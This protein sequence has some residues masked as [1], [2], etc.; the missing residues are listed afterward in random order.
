M[1]GMYIRVANRIVN[2]TNITDIEEHPPEEEGQ[3]RALVINFVGS[4]GLTLRG[5]E[6]DLFLA[7]LPVY[8]PVLGED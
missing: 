6:A 7:S 8:Q 5:E 2:T 4:G 3:E 1:H